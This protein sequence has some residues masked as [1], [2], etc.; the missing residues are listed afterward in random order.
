MQVEKRVVKIGK[1]EVHFIGTKHTFESDIRK[2]KV[3][4]FEEKLK[5]I[6]K[7]FAAIATEGIRKKGGR[8][9]IRD[10]LAKKQK[11]FLPND[12]KP[13]VEKCKKDGLNLVFID[14]ETSTYNSHQSFYASE[15]SAA[16]NKADGNTKKLPWKWKKILKNSGSFRSLVMASNLE[17]AVKLH[18]KH[19]GEPVKIAVFAHET[20][21]E[22]MIKLLEDPKYQKIKETVR[23]ATRRKYGS[24][25]W[26]GILVLKP[27]NLAVEEENAG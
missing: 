2:R 27:E 4:G 19:A 10:A 5:K 17:Q 3:Y 12:R 14:S 7:G 16:R 13:L 9:K 20:H 21:A 24:S 1:S 6:G 22:E 23:K 25:A 8:Q 11:F 15:T 26:K 18:E